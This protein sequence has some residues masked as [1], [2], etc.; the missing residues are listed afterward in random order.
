VCAP[1]RADRIANG[2]RIVRAGTAALTLDGRNVVA[3]DDAIAV[4]TPFGLNLVVAPG[5]HPP[6][7]SHGVPWAGQFPLEKASLI[8]L[9]DRITAAVLR[10]F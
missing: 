5:R 2:K 9:S 4:P 1:D 10:R 3:G 6:L 8:Y 7:A